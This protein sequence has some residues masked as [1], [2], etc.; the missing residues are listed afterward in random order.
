MAQRDIVTIGGSAGSI[1]SLARIVKALPPDLPAAVFIIVHRRSLE[2]SWLAYLLNRPGALRACEAEDNEWISSGRIYV[3][4]PDRHL[5]IAEGHIHLTRG[6]K[7]GL[8]RPSITRRSGLR[9][10]H[11]E[12]ESLECCFP[13]CLTTAPPVYGKSSIVEEFLSFSIP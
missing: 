13:E 2:N 5:V 1:E 4:P 9:R 8:H 11:T 7:E 6:P 3:A 10:P 12:T